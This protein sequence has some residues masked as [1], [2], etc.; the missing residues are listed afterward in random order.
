MA[1]ANFMYAVNVYVW[2]NAFLCEKKTK[3]QQLHVFMC[4]Y[5]VFM[6]VCMNLFFDSKH[7]YIN[8]H[9]LYFQL[10]SMV[11]RPHLPSDR[12]SSFESLAGLPAREA[13]SSSQPQTE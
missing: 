3:Q 2:M 1:R 10:H 6:Y 4:I 13:C 8:I 11:S 9:T 5:V 7:S 12:R